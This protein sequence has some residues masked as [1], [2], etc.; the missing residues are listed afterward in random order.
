MLGD[1]NANTIKFKNYVCLYDFFCKPQFN[2]DEETRQSLEPVN[3][4]L[5]SNISRERSSYDIQ[6]NSYGLN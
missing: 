1:F 3:V 5:D 4:L 6:F 2:T